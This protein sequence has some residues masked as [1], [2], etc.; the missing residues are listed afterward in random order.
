MGF[1][2]SGC[3]RRLDERIAGGVEAFA[4]VLFA[5]FF[6]VFVAEFGH[7]ALDGPSDGFAVGADGAAGYLI[8]Y[9]FEEGYVFFACLAGAHAS[10]EL[11]EPE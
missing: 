9:V 6:E 8:G 4:G 10:A 1:I 5:D 2:M 11:L 3:G 7:G